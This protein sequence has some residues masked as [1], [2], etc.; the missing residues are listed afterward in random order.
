VT[1]EDLRFLQR[2][3]DVKPARR[4]YG[5]NVPSRRAAAFGLIGFDPGVARKKR[6]EELL[7]PNI[8]DD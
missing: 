5:P 4:G 2:V 3:D 7:T 1:C 6:S 8:G